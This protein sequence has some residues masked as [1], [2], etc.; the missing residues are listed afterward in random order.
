MLSSRGEKSQRNSLKRFVSRKKVDLDFVAL[1]LDFG[2]FFLG[3][4]CGRL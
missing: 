3:F 4:C 2:S 1:G